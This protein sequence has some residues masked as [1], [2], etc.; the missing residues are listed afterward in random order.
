MPP[1]QERD[2][3]DEVD[4]LVHG[5]QVNYSLEQLRLVGVLLLLIVLGQVL[6]VL[7]LSAHGDPLQRLT[8]LSALANWLPLLPLGTSLYLLAGGRRRH[9]RELLLIDLLNHSLVPLALACLFALP[10]LVV[11][12][13]A[14]LTWHHRA[15]ESSHA[16]LVKSHQDWL[17]TA[18]RAPSAAIVN[19]LATLHR[20]EVP[21]ASDDP[22]KLAQWRLA[23]ALEHNANQAKAANPLLN[24][25]PYQLDLLAP[26]KTATTLVLTTIAGMGLVLLDRQGRRQMRRHGLTP[27]LFFRADSTGKRQRLHRSRTSLSNG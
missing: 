17:A 27:A 26:W 5:H 15:A 23:Q 3:R 24:L 25:S 1:V 16:R 11:T 18:E 13:V 12:D 2:T 7:I 19:Q 9:P 21:I 22:V 10:I 14:N 8:A 4:A 6:V 20:L